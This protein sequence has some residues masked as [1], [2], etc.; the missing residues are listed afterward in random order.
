MALAPV[1]REGQIVRLSPQTP[2]A[3]YSIVSAGFGRVLGMRLVNGRWL[4]DHE[5]DLAVMINESFARV[6]FGNSAPIGRRILVPGFTPGP[7][8]SSAT[9]VGVVGDLRYRRLD[10]GPPPEVYLPFLQSK[11]L[12][13][14]TV[15]VRTSGDAYAV[16]PAIRTMVAEIDATQP[17]RRIGNSGT[18]PVGVCCAAEVQPASPGNVRVGSTSAR[19][20]RDL[21]SDRVRRDAAHAGNWYP[22]CLRA[23]AK[24][25]CLSG[26]DIN[27]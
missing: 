9:V 11:F 18:L 22:C 14:A 21:R 2:M 26:S 5:K 19:S 20:D 10:S 8:A 6:A 7:Q 27:H 24:I 4:T 3:S 12:V 23:D 1:Q 16:A 25:T 13:R 15:L 17:T